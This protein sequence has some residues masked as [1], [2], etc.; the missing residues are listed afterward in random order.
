MDEGYKGNV[1]TPPRW[2]ESLPRPA[3]AQLEG[4][5]SSQSWFEVY[6]VGPDVYVFYEPGQFEE[7][8]SYLVLGEEKAAVVDT[9]CGIGNIKALAEEF[10]S[11][12]LTV[13][14][15]HSHYDHVAQNYLFDE[16]AIFD[17]PMAR[18]TAG[19]G[20][21]HKKMMK[22]LED[23][24]VW[25]PLPEE[26][27][28]DEYHVPPFKVTRW[29]RNGD[30]VDLGGRELEVFHTPGHSPDS[31]CLL[32]RD[33]RLF[34]TGDIFYTGAI[35]TYL[36]GGDLNQFIESY[37]LMI[38]LFPH[39]DMLMPS[40]NE[41]YIE[42]EILRKVLQAAEDIRAGRGEY[43]KGKEGIRRYNYSKFALIMAPP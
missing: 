25:K 17:D 6:R 21:T 28:P 41:P 26:F 37:K 35:Y 27:K 24:K 23:G 12:P 29:L 42:K 39:Y 38:D 8:I 2:W 31:V 5:E 30:I 33:A 32:D 40:H 22:V 1:V 18:E 13:V 43:I 7:V 19:K 4:I 10:T 11:L 3:Y 9:G 14:N 34:W 20:Y 36:P 16:I 15:T